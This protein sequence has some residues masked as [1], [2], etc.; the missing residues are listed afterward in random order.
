MVMNDE[1]KMSVANAV[2]ARMETTQKSQNQVARE[3]QLSAATLSNCLN[4]KWENISAEVWRSLSRYCGIKSQQ[5]PTISTKNFTA[6]QEL[7]KDAKD[8]GRM[9]AVAGAT[10]LGKTKALEHFTANNPHVF[11]VL[12]TSTMGRGDLIAAM[13][14]SWGVSLEAKV[15]LRLLSVIEALKRLENPLLILDD[16]GKLNDNCQLLIQIMYDALGEHCGFVL[17]GTD[18]FKREFFKK[19]ARDKNGFRELKRR[20]G[21]WQRLVEPSLGAVKMLC[22]QYEIVDPAVWSYMHNSFKDYGTLREVIV[23]VCR[24]QEPV[25]VELIQ[26]LRVGG[27]L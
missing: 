2:K 15:H 26:R 16:C 19:A 20:I 14:R 12:C 3:L 1:F 11:Y 17:S 23:N 7:C 18:A 24:V 13:Q 5:W 27:E 6:I 10:G 22:E 4:G 25:T 9:L 8:N 21:Y